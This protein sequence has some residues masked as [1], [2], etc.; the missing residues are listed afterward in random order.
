LVFAT[1]KIL[2]LFIVDSEVDYLCRYR[3]AGAIIVG[4]ICGMRRL[5]P[6]VVGICSLLDLYSLEKIDTACLAWLNNWSESA[7][8]PHSSK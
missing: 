7:C 2:R 6:W 5:W 1:E 3:P 8:Y 4:K